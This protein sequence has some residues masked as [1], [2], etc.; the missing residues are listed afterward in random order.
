MLN[1]L[2]VKMCTVD[3]GYCIYVPPGILRANSY[4]VLDKAGRAA[5]FDE[6]SLRMDNLKNLSYHHLSKF[7]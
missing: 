4:F 6:F 2:I 1:H 7:L 5:N 3:A